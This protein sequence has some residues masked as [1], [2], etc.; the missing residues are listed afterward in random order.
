MEDRFPNPLLNGQS[1]QYDCSDGTIS[2]AR[3]MLAKILGSEQIVSNPEECHAHSITKWSPAFR[4]QVPSL[5]VFPQ[6]TS[7]VSATMNICSQNKIPVVGY[8]GGTSM[9][10]AI[11]ATRGGICVD[12]K[13]MNRILAIHQEDMDVVVQPAVDWQEL[14]AHLETHDL[15]FP[16][17]PS[18]GARIGGM[19]SLSS[20]QSNR[21]VL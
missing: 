20:A 1:S 17:D 7:D 4:S 16:P 13:R 14:N 8:S 18:P 5:V 6:S 12:F 11:A 15:F 9:P 21:G 2:K 19:V 10:G 3:D